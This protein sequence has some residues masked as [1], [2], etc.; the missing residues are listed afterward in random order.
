M[1]L[2]SGVFREEG[3][4]VSV[5]NNYCLSRMYPLR[6]FGNPEEEGWYEIGIVL[7]FAQRIRRVTRVL[8]EHGYGILPLTAYLY[9]RYTGF[10]ELV[11]EVHRDMV[12]L[13]CKIVP[14]RVVL[15]GGGA[16]VL[17]H[18][19]PVSAKTDIMGVVLLFLI[20]STLHL[21]M[22]RGYCLLR[23]VRIVREGGFYRFHMLF[24]GNN[25]RGVMKF[26]FRFPG[27]VHILV[28]G[29]LVGG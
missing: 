6:K 24:E 17:Q 18:T 10:E 3:I 9:S 27:K 8:L 11:P 22:G 23:D 15:G 1:G 12:V 25:M 21:R 2:P 16:H 5:R 7:D 13:E 14:V 28:G 19:V 26:P 4:M 29:L 20:G